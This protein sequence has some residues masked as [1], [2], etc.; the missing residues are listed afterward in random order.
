MKIQVHQILSGEHNRQWSLL[1]T[2][3]TETAVAEK[4]SFKTDLQDKVTGV[5]WTP[6]LRAFSYNEFFLIIRTFQDESSNVRRGR[7]LSHVLVV[8]REDLKH[9]SDLGVLIKHLQTHPDK[10]VSLAVITLD[11]ERSESEQLSE[12]LKPRFSSAIKC[13]LDDPSWRKP[14]VW[15]GQRDYEQ[16]AVGIWAILSSGQRENVYLGIHFN[17]NQ[18]PSGKLAFITTPESFENKFANSKFCCIRRNDAHMPVEIGEKLLSGDAEAGQRIRLFNTAIGD[19]DLS[20]EKL[21]NIGK[22]IGTFENLKATTDLKSIVT[23]S[24]VVAEY[25]PKKENGKQFK[26]ELISQLSNAI[27]TAQSPG[28]V[29][30]RDIRVD[31]FSD[32]VTSI[33][34]A[35]RQWAESKLFNLSANETNDFSSLIKKI[36]DPADKTWWGKFLRREVVSFVKITREENAKIVALWTNQSPSILSSLIV[37]IDSSATSETLFMEAIDSKTSPATLS[38]FIKL[39][40]DFKWY[41]LHAQLVKLCLDF[42]EAVATHLRFDTNPSYFD[43]VRIL[44]KD[45]AREKIIEVSIVTGDDRLLQLS[46]EIIQ[47]DP[48]LIG[49]I[50]IA[51]S[52][53]QSIVV[54]AY[55]D[56]FNF[57]LES[58][59]PGELVNTIF[60]LLLNDLPVSRSILEIVAETTFGNLLDYEWRPLLWKKLPEDVREKFLLKTSTAF[61]GSLSM[62]SN[63]NV[64]EDTTLSDYIVSSNAIEKFLYFNRSNLVSVLPLFVSHTEMPEHII[65]GYL[66]NFAGNMEI[67]QATQLGRLINGRGYKTVAKIVA[68]KAQYN[69]SWRPCLAECYAL[70]GVFAQLRLKW[71]GIVSDI[72]IGE[73]QFWKAMFDLVIK[74][75]PLGPDQNKIWEQAGGDE[76][77]IDFR[78]NGR[79]IW[80]STLDLLRRGAFRD[81]S[82]KKLLKA[83]QNDFPNNQDIEILREYWKNL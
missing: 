24:H 23:L 15:I 10:E 46:N 70:L 43:G 35:L 54:K 37:A 26:S 18:V 74:Q 45:V 38:E 72:V 82:V 50:D 5:N 4:I 63:M 62:N 1:K 8:K 67:L 11:L 34:E 14:I 73:D 16:T 41:R 56:G 33:Q 65:A 27:S 75:Y 64:P 81:V 6:V 47:A 59:G 78:G 76:S 20:L 80:Y 52:N 7:V 61:L 79:E 69:F 21:V 2:S 77:E 30:L 36:L 31:S 68:E 66:N 40:V 39:S 44:V 71:Q 29:L 25:S 53:G 51:S 58:S 83:M 9:I 49:Q 22:V 19:D 42:Q 3:M 12:D 60:S 55:D 17:V 48:K 28:I 57:I 32:S 13:M